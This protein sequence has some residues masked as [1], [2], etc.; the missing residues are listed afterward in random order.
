MAVPSSEALTIV[1][2][3]LLK[4]PESEAS[5]LYMSKELTAALCPISFSLTISDVFSISK[6]LT[7]VAVFFSMIINTI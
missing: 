5:G 1:C 4:Y 2:L 3:N 7:Y 6:S